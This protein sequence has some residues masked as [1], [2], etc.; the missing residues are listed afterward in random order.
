[1]LAGGGLGGMAS[2]LASLSAP[3][4]PYGSGGRA[5]LRFIVGLREPLSLGLSNWMW[6]APLRQLNSGPER[7]FEKGLGLFEF[8]ERAVGAVGQPHMLLQLNQTET[9]RYYA[10]ISRLSHEHAEADKLMGAHYALNI[11]AY[12]R[13]GFNG[14][15]FLLVPTATLNEPQVLVQSAASFLGLTLPAGLVLPR[16]C[17]PKRKPSSTSQTNQLSDNRTLAEVVDGFQRTATAARARAYFAAHNTA[18]LRL[19]RSQA[20]NVAGEV[21]G[22]LK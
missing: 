21:P 16:A 9:R 7:W 13:R 6:L 22:W 14:S 5:A 1:M 10:C 3:G 4:G 12:L 11:H 8:C 17:M 20:V 19:I 15:Q 18:L 2:Q